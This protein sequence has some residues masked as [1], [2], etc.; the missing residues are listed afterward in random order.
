MGT[1][2]GVRNTKFSIIEDYFYRY[3]TLQSQNCVGAPLAQLVE[4]QTLDHKVAGSNLTRG[5]VLSP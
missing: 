1:I 3:L 4:C 5:T 2:I